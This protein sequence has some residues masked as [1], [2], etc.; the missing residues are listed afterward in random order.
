[1][2]PKITQDAPNIVERY[3]CADC[4][5]S[6]P[7]PDGTA[8]GVKSDPWRYCPGCGAPIEY[9]KAKHVQWK[10]QKC[11]GCGRP[12]IYLAGAGAPGR[13]LC[14]DQLPAVRYRSMA[15][16]PLC[17]YQAVRDGK[18]GKIGRGR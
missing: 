18:S 10:E 14:A 12:L 5:R 2:I 1:M 8:M 3:W 7:A 17:L 15:G 9:D 13:A 6:L 4:G 11:T 16:L